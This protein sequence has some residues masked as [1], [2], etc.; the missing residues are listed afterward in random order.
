MEDQN[1]VGNLL[2]EG[3]LSSIFFSTGSWVS[4]H[5]TDIAGDQFDEAE[6]EKDLAALLMD[7]PSSGSSVQAGE[8]DLERRLLA[9]TIADKG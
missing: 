7:E 5:F 1:E 9:L 6:L 3:I 4:V 8:I 2:A